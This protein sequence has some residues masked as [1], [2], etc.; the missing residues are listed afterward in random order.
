MYWINFALPSNPTPRDVNS[1][2]SPSVKPAPALYPLIEGGDCVI[3]ETVKEPVRRD[4]EDVVVP[5]S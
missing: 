4:G 3:D 1:S 2:T 5:C